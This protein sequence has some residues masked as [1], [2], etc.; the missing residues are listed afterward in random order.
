[1]PKPV[2][3]GTSRRRDPRADETVTP[4]HGD[5]LEEQVKA[6]ATGVSQ[7]DAQRREIDMRAAH[8][9]WAKKSR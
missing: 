1:M 9:R 4:P 5:P 3:S 2:K 6:T 7:T 8:A